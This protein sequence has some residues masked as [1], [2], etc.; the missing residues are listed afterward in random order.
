MG[1]L[2]SLFG[3]GTG[4]NVAKRFDVQLRVAQGTMS[5]V[6]KAYDRQL[7][8]TV[9]LK[10]LDK[11]KTSEF[12]KRFQGFKDKKPTEGKISEQLKHPNIVVTYEHGKTSAGEQYL[13][14]EWIEG[15][16]LSTLIESKSPRLIGHRVEIAVQLCDAVAY[17]HGLKFLHRDLCP[18]NIIVTP[19]GV[20][21]L[22]DFGLTVP[23]TPDYCQPGN[24]TG[25]QDYLAPEIM[26]RQPTDHR[27]DLFALGATL[28]ELFAG[29]VPWERSTTGEDNFRRRLNT[30]PR[31]PCDLNPDLDDEIAAVLTKGIA[32]ERGSRYPTALAMKQ[33][34]E[35]LERQD[36]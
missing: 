14:T 13:V 27:V 22:I 7:G 24:R 17:L 32:I 2:D 23:Y 25:K 11:V 8:R 31:N 29:S 3:G 1:I 18:H 35:S 15:T 20:A 16:A 6:C 28:F 21:K 4:V 12:E 10:V 9:C 26:R 33:A 36:Y 34:Y 30:P 19:D 5:K